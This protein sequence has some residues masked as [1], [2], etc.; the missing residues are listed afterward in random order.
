MR[1]G[2]SS[3]WSVAIHLFGFFSILH[4]VLTAV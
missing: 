4:D 1:R 2:D 3:L